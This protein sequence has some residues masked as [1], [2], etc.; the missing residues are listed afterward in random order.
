LKEFAIARNILVRKNIKISLL[1]REIN[2]LLLNLFLILPCFC[3]LILIKKADT[4][5]NTKTEAVC[6]REA[7]HYCLGEVLEHIHEDL[8]FS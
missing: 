6:G 8:N 7:L 5:S 3:Y 2:F 4:C 1:I